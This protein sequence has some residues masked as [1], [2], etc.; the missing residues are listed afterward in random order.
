MP[1][2]SKWIQVKADPAI[3]RKL[4][5]LAELKR[6]S[7]SDTV[8]LLIEDEYQRLIVAP[9]NGDGLIQPI[10]QPETMAA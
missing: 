8:R 4:R 3:K 5:K 6:R 10:A 7:D 9:Q 2:Y 1:K